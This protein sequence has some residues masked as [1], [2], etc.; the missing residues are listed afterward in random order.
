MQLTKKQ[1]AVLLY[2]PLFWLVWAGV[3]LGL[4]PI[5]EQE[6]PPD[7][8]VLFLIK[9][10]LLKVLIWIVPAVLLIRKFDDEMQ[11]RLREMFT[12]RFDWKLFLIVLAALCGLTIGNHVI[13]THSLQFHPTW[14]LLGFILVGFTEEIVFRG[15]LLNAMQNEKNQKFMPEING[16]LFVLIHIPCWIHEHI[17]D[18]AFLHL[19]FLSVLAVGILFAW[20]FTRFRSIYPPVILHIAYDVLLTMMK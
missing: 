5:F 11:V 9:E 14:R 3:E 15:W 2:F 1:W 12:G 17:M 7:S 20:S 10:G 16:A 6:F 8:T 18:Q 13:S 4:M 19:G